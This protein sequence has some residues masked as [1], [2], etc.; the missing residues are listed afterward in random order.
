MVSVS[1]LSALMSDA[2]LYSSVCAELKFG[3][4]KCIASPFQ[5]AVGYSC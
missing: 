3:L 1:V 2:R 4:T 5:T